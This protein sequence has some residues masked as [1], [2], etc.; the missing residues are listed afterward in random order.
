MI[1]EAK[2]VS[3]T[4]KKK[5]S[6]FPHISQW[7]LWD[8]ILWLDFVDEHKFV[9]LSKCINCNEG[10]TGNSHI[11]W[12]YKFRTIIYWCQISHRCIWCCSGA[13]GDLWRWVSRVCNLRELRRRLQTRRTEDGGNNVVQVKQ[14]LYHNGHPSPRRLWQTPPP[15]A[16]CVFFTGLLSVSFV[17][18]YTSPGGGV[19]LHFLDQS[20]CTG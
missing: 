3:K 16:C 15:P 2:L 19:G 12:S 5:F 11:I 17:G 20:L 4:C 9:R 18:L 14:K 7:I 8:M 1:Y 13:D 6:L 10:N